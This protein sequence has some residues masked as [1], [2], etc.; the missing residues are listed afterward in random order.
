MAT[1]HHETASLAPYPLLLAGC[2]CADADSLDLI[3]IAVEVFDG[4]DC[5]HCLATGVVAAKRFA[6]ASVTPTPVVVTL[7]CADP[8]VRAARELGVGMGVGGR[9]RGAREEG[10]EEEEDGLGAEGVYGGTLR[11]RVSS[12]VVRG[13]Y[14]GHAA[15]DQATSARSPL[16]AHTYVRVLCARV[17]SGVGGGTIGAAAPKTGNGVRI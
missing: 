14:G 15:A 10:D 13:T 4:P 5:D 16:A 7:Q 9:G 2:I 1:W 12:I 11:L 6:A 8:H 17:A 3:H